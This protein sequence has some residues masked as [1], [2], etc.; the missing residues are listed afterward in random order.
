[1]KKTALV[2]AAV[3]ALVATAATAPAQARGFGVAAGT[4]ARMVT[5]PSPDFAG[6]T[7]FARF[8]VAASLGSARDARHGHRDADG[9]GSSTATR[10][11]PRSSA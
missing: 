4:T 2:L 5:V 10:H 9:E 6:R 1:M 3:T 8:H 7:T 11:A